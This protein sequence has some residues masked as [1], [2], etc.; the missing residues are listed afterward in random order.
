MKFYELA[1]YVFQASPNTGKRKTQICLPLRSPCVARVGG[2]YCV[3]GENGGPP[4][5]RIEVLSIASV[6]VRYTL[7]KAHV[8]ACGY[9][10]LRDFLYVWAYRYD[11]DFYTECILGKKLHK[12]GISLRGLVNARPST[13]YLAWRVTFEPVE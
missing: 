10:T 5:G 11:E 13:N 3:T 8:A 1:P 2:V 4:L 12:K 6:D 9:L 7:L